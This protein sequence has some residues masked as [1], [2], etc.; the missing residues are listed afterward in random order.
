VLVIE[1]GHAVAALTAV[2]SVD[3]SGRTLRDVATLER[4]EQAWQRQLASLLAQL[5]VQP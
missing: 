3:R 4:M 2:R 5:K 1:A